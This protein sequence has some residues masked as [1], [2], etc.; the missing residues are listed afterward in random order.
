M[1]EAYQSGVVDFVVSDAD[2]DHHWPTTAA[3]AVDRFR[4]RQS[5]V[6]T[7]DSNH[8]F[9][10][11][12]DKLEDLVAVY[13]LDEQAQYINPAGRRALGLEAGVNITSM[14]LS[15]IFPEWE[16]TTLRSESIPK[17]ID[18][19]LW[20]GEMTLF[21]RPGSQFVASIVVLA[22]RSD[23]QPQ[24]ISIIARDIAE[25][26]KYRQLARESAMARQALSVITTR[27]REV[28]DLVVQGRPNKVIAGELFLSEKTIEKHRARLKAKLKVTSNAELVRLG[29]MAG[30]P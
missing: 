14:D 15:D 18:H 24:S 13:S 26:R 4:H 1:V 28:F 11:I 6:S 10:E 20:T 12:V 16:L 21:R 19:G 17:A 5:A 29:V 30:L 23:G 8:R 2:D 22:N 27:E 9:G 25:R 3:R 7:P